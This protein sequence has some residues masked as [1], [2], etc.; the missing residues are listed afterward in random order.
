MNLAIGQERVRFQILPASASGLRID[1][2]V[3]IR[4]RL[5]VSVTAAAAQDMNRQTARCEILTSG[6]E[7]DH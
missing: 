5:E 1:L 3:I 2:V 4:P 6:I 7:K